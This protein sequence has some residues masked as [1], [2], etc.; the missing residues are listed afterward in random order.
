MDLI[1]FTKNEKDQYFRKSTEFAS[2][3]V[4]LK[5]DAKA[6][7][8]VERLS[9]VLLKGVQDA[10]WDTV[11]KKRRSMENDAVPLVAELK[12]EYKES[13]IRNHILRAKKSSGSKN[14]DQL[15]I[16]AERDYEMRR[17][18][19]DSLAEKKVWRDLI[20]RE[21]HD[22]DLTL[23][24]DGKSIIDYARVGGSKNKRLIDDV[25]K[26]QEK[27][28]NWTEKHFDLETGMIVSKEEHG[29]LF[30]HSSYKYG[31]GVVP[32]IELQ[33]SKRMI[34]MILFLS[35]CSFLRYHTDSYISLETPNAIRL[36]E[37]LIDLM[38]GTLSVS[39]RDLTSEFLQHKFN[40]KYKLFRSFLQ[41]VIDPA[42]E[43]INAE[44]K[45][46]ISWEAHK[47][48]GK[49]IYS[50]KFNISQDDRMRLKGEEDGFVDEVLLYSFE[51]YLALVSLDGQRTLQRISD[52]S[53]KI[54]GLLS[55]DQYEYN[56]LTKEEAF[57]RYQQNLIDIEEIQTLLE[58]DEYLQ[59][60]YM[61]DRMYLNIFDKD[62][63]IFVGA[64]ATES[65]RYIQA[66]YLVPNGMLNLPLP[67][68][69]SYTEELEVMKKILPIR[70]KQTPKRKIL[71]DIINFD[72]MKRTIEPF[73]EDV[74]RFEF[75]S[76]AQEVLFRKIFCSKNTI[77]PTFLE[78]E[79]VEE[80]PETIDDDKDVRESFTVL[81]NLLKK[82]KNL[83]VKTNETSW[84]ETYIG[85]V[86]EYGTE[87]VDSAIFFLSTGTK[88]AL[89]WLKQIV[90]P[91]KFIQHFQ[92]IH[93]VANV[94]SISNFEELRK[95]GRIQARIKLMGADGCSE[96]EIEAEVARMIAKMSAK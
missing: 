74:E 16:D 15:Q 38:D 4:I 67:Y 23:K 46:N 86:D 41:M 65:L 35:N 81:I 53:D 85:I 80:L 70:F 32:E 58:E 42:I 33:I 31:R 45:T 83:S 34:H 87:A 76:P 26:V 6:S 1:V 60:K 64:T 39:R 18:N 49:S 9:A 61:F 93:Q 52:M 8:A 69:G 84:K 36:Y 55:E 73:I 30:P 7:G 68:F 62:E 10:L 71:I 22:E 88:D 91:S 2:A 43:K 13:Y 3:N 57:Q 27:F 50:I 19:I 37:L 21:I 96:E 94:A 63:E 79:V 12:E 28:T 17:R 89:F 14:L 56:G 54:R 78:C 75:D 40:T 5:D 66:S 59:S 77:A 47:R 92:A 44:L 29:V 51:Y 20:K 25:Q 48:T 95:D 90:T 72:K 11:M 82:I 24:F